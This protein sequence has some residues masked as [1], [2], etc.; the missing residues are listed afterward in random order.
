MQEPNSGCTRYEYDGLNALISETGFRHGDRA[1]APCGAASK[2]RNR[3]TYDYA[4]DRMVRMSYHSLDEQGGALDERDAVRVFYDRSP[5]AIVIGTP[6]EAQRFVPNY[7]ANQRFVD[8]AGRTCD[9]CIGQATVVADRTG[10]R[11]YAYNELGLAR[12]EVRSVVAGAR[13][14][15]QR[16]GSETT[17]PRLR[18]TSSRAPTRPSGTPSWRGSRK[19][20]R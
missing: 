6:Y 17:F 5:S 8:A 14:P 2:V 15:A 18:S 16:G 20:R 3:K 4:G 13:R 1:E 9:N 7:Q 19:A 11:A 12:R 10:A